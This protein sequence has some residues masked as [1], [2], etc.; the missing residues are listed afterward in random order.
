MDSMGPPGLTNHG[1]GG[2]HPR[3]PGLAQDGT[4]Q[5]RMALIR[6]ITRRMTWLAVTRGQP[7]IG[8]AQ[9][10]ERSRMLITEAGPRSRL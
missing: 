9:N 8:A 1:L 7:T 3:P 4:M 2:R 10:C 5:L 6:S